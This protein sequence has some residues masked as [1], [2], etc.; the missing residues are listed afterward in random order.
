MPIV[1]HRPLAEADR[2]IPF[3]NN[4]GTSVTIPY[5]KTDIETFIAKNKIANK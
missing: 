1:G 4:K 3:P 2:Q 5:T